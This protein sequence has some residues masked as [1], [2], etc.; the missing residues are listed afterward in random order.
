MSTLEIL[1]INSHINQLINSIV[2]EDDRMARKSYGENIMDEV[3]KI[4]EALIGKSEA[5]P[6]LMS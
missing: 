6:Q 2:L 3:M 5:S 4:S 1:K